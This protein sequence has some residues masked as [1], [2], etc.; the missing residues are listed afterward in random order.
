MAITATGT[1]A[2][3]T[4][5]LPSGFVVPAVAALT[6]PSKEP[7]TNIAFT[8]VTYA[9]ATVSATGLTALIAGVKAWVEATFLPGLGVLA[10]S[11]IT[12][13]FV[14]TAVADG[15][16]TYT[17]GDEANQYL[18]GTAIYKV[19]GYVEWVFVA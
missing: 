6:N 16:S 11:T 10:T 18:T 12:A 13:R 7:F 5:K 14:I 4:N 9:H 19:S 17:E 8:R 3:P 2:R 15:Y 1:I